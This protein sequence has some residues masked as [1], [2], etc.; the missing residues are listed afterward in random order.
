MDMSKMPLLGRNGLVNAVRK[1]TDMPTTGWRKIDP[2]ATFIAGQLAKLAMIDGEPTVQTVSGTSD[3]PVGVYFTHNTVFF[4]IPVVDEAH[5]F[6][7]NS[8]APTQ[9]FLK[10]YVKTGYYIITNVAKNVT[11]AE[12]VDYTINLTNGVVTYMG[13]TLTTGS[14][15]VVNYQY[16]DVN[17]SG[18]SQTM[19]SGK[20]CLLEEVGEIGTLVYDTKAVWSIGAAVK[21]DASGFFTTA[22][23]SATIGRVTGVPT[24]DNPELMIKINLA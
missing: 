23:G 21:F 9:I 5:T 1:I 3:V 11:Y 6:G 15:V 24:S 10:P 16:K 8:S 19:G 4:Y 18:I 17:L 22:A 2:S 7:E 13:P 14:A 12:G 20:A